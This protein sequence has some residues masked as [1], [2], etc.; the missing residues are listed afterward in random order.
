MKRIFTFIAAAT[1][2]VSLSLPVRA[3][4]TINAPAGWTAQ[5]RAKG[6]TTFT[7]PDLAA[8]EIYSTTVY[9][10]AP[11]GGKTL[12]EWLRGFGGAVGKAPGHLAAPLQIKVSEGR[13]VSGVGAYN[14]PKGTALGVMFIGVSLDGGGNIHASRTLF[15]PQP[16]RRVPPSNPSKT[17]RP[18]QRAR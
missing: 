5:T 6:A 17:A 2:A 13:V 16:V 4:M 15:S 3:Q 8:G 11:L 9:D 18:T 1:L 14:G 7:P 12:E 10:S